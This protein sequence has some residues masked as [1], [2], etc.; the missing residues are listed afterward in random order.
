MRVVLA[1]PNYMGGSPSKGRDDD[2]TAYI[3]LQVTPPEPL[4][5]GAEPHR[6]EV[7][8]KEILEVKTVA[9]IGD[10][11]VS[12]TTG[13]DEK[14]LICVEDLAVSSEYTFKVRCADANGETY[15]RTV[16]TTEKTVQGL[17]YETL[18][19]ELEKSASNIHAALETFMESASAP[20]PSL[21]PNTDKDI[22]VNKA[23]QL[24]HA[25]QGFEDR[26]EALEGMRNAVTEVKDKSE[27]FQTLFDDT[28]QQL[29][30]NKAKHHALCEEKAAELPG[31]LN[32]FADDLKV[33]SYL[34]QKASV[35][36]EGKILYE[37][38]DGIPSEALTE[39][40][41]ELVKIDVKPKD[42]R[43]VVNTLKEAANKLPADYQLKGA[44]TKLAKTIEP[45]KDK[46]TT[47]N[48]NPPSISREQS[49]LPG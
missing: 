28:L 32:K 20:P 38:A 49:T 7:T 21:D 36:K 30:K 10:P 37:F 3:W 19:R 14:D 26:R 42:V 17:P 5:V 31:E 34:H 46:V 8:Y 40:V 22:I 13:R 24:V 41:M 47:F 43:G 44:I 9:F 45:V 16:Q 2:G 29:T 6:Y 1:K 35:E 18:K 12:K 11:Y 25:F 33:N 39:D 23:N 4:P 27:Q 15:G 48:W